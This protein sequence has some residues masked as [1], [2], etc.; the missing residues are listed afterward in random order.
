[1]SNHPH[2]VEQPHDA[3]AVFQRYEP[4]DYVADGD[5][6]TGKFYHRFF[7]DGAPHRC[8]RVA[9]PDQSRAVVTVLPGGSVIPHVRYA[10]ARIEEVDSAV[11][12][13]ELA[14]VS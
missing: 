8:A 11:F 2:L 5:R 10:P 4:G 14:Y 1:M 3:E 9:F 12:E 7:V 13:A 6:K